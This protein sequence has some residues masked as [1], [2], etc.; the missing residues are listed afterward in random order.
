VAGT[1]AGLIEGRLLF[2]PVFWAEIAAFDS[3]SLAQKRPRVTGLLIMLGF[4]AITFS[5]VGPNGRPRKS[6]DRSRDGCPSRGR[7]GRLPD[8]DAKK[9]AAGCTQA[10]ESYEQASPLRKAPLCAASH[11]ACAR[12]SINPNLKL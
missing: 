8:D 4:L 10:G 3:Y 5:Y 7:V 1:V 2:V 12:A 6:A 11:S 9:V